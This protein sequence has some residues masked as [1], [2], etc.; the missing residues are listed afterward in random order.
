[1]FFEAIKYSAQSSVSRAGAW[2][3][4]PG[5][6][7]VWLGLRMMGYQIAAP[8]TLEQG[9]VAFL[10]CAGVAWFIIFA[11]R[12]LYWPYRELAAKLPA[13]NHV[14]IDATPEELLSLGKDRTTLERNKITKAYIG[15]WLK[16]SGQVSDVMAYNRNAVVTVTMGDTQQQIELVF[17]AKWFERVTILMIGKNI[18]AIGQILAIYRKSIELQNC[19]L[20]ESGAN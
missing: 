10:L 4:L 13:S 7:V 5:A 18:T 2:A 12:L 19:E 3:P 15:N 17:N 20:M 6:L 1:M 11:A 8:E 14:L 9:I 16:V